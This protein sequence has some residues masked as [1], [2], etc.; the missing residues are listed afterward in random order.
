[1]TIIQ[2]AIVENEAVYVKQTEEMIHKWKNDNNIY[3]E[4]CVDVFSSGED[5]LKSKASEYHIIFMDIQLE[6]KLDGIQ[7]AKKLRQGRCNVPLVFLTSFS[8]YVFTGYEVRA[9]NYIVK[10]VEY[11]RVAWCM[12]RIF[13]MEFQGYYVFKERDRIHK[14][15]Y[16]KILYFQSSLHY[17][18]I[19]TEKDVFRHKMSFKK[20]QRLLPPQ[21]IPC[22]RTVIANILKVDCLAGRELT[23]SDGSVLPISNTYIKLV[24]DM[25]L[26]LMME[27]K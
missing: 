12:N 3:C 9:L 8:Q 14:V 27:D 6:G 21:F 24:R 17:V 4:L 25:Y 15:S 26:K 16:N 19:Y 5:F 2:V 18:D 20:L 13:E 11:E 23:M 1:M 10:P 22:H 7:T